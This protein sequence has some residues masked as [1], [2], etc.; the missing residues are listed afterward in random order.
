MSKIINKKV[1]GLVG[2]SLAAALVYSLS[3]PAFSNTSGGGSSDAPVTGTIGAPY[4]WEAVVTTSG[5]GNTAWDKFH[6]YN[7]RGT[8]AANKA[9][10]ELRVIQ[11]GAN[12]NSCKNSDVIWYFV[13]KQKNGSQ[14]KWLHNFSSP[15]GTFK[16][17]DKGSFNYDQAM[18]HNHADGYVHQT[19]YRPRIFG[20][21]Q[22][23]I[24]IQHIIDWDSTLTRSTPRLFNTVNNS[25]RS[26]YNI[27]CSSDLPPLLPDPQERTINKVEERFKEESRSQT[28]NKPHSYITEVKPQKISDPNTG[29]SVKIGTTNFIAQSNSKITEYGKVWDKINNGSYKNNNYNSIKKII[30]DAIKAD[31]GSVA[32]ASVDLNDNNQRA[33]A[34]GGVLNVTKNSAT[35]RITIRENKDLVQKRTCS[36]TERRTWNKAANKWNSW[37]EISR[38]CPKWPTN[39]TTVDTSVSKTAVNT[40]T[41]N[42]LAFYQILSVHC[43]KEGYDN[44]INSMPANRITFNEYTDNSDGSISAYAVTRQ[45]NNEAAMRAANGGLIFGDHTSEN[46]ARKASGYVSF[47]DKQCAF[48]CVSDSED[49]SENRP[50]ES[51]NAVNNVNDSGN[52]QNLYG[53]TSTGREINSNYFQF[54]RDGE[55]EQ[56]YIDSWYPKRVDGVLYDGEAAVSTTVSRWAEGTPGVTNDSG[57]KFTMS[58]TDG[59]ELFTGSENNTVQK[60]WNTSDTYSNST[61]TKVLGQHNTFNVKANWAS[62]TNKPQ[63]LNFKWDYAPEVQS[64]MFKTVGFA[65]D[66]G[67]MSNTN[68]TNMTANITGKCIGTFGDNPYPSFYDEMITSTGTGTTNTIDNFFGATSKDNQ[69]GVAIEY[70]RATTE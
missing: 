29:E 50:S 8:S 18:K 25:S 52:V 30:D 60:N 40:G 51:N 49:S 41:Q 46:N 22:I 19:L 1:L 28:Y 64:S 58:L 61:T 15:W 45:Y 34:E 17:G 11:T 27:I 10:T 7:G 53:A 47:Y 59:T 6:K 66:G 67:V 56:L 32:H 21:G 69:H 36:T 43:N 20:G 5:S 13:G 33:L 9:Q 35:Q 70:V 23:N 65:G 44:L 31:E 24:P 38:N 26:S 16:W 37:T 54:F 42:Q 39:W 14:T 12:L 48:Q 57:G 68:L 55:N 3:L 62:E 4:G 2:V 63:V